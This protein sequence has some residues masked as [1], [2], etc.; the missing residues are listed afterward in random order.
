[1]NNIQE[2]GIPAEPG[3]FIN[4]SDMM[5]TDGFGKQ[6]HYCN[7]SL[8]GQEYYSGVDL[9]RSVGTAIFF[10]YYIG[11][12]ATTGLIS[13]IFGGIALGIRYGGKD[14]KTTGGVIALVI[15]FFLCLASMTFSIISLKMNLDEVNKKELPCY[16][17]KENKVIEK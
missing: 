11:S 9:G 15:F 14:K 12:I 1:M 4:F 2:E 3:K 8:N 16:S 5:Y 17:N 7:T 13:I 10:P 6:M